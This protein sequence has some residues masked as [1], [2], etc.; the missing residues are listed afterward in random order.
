MDRLRVVGGRL[1]GKFI[2]VLS[3]VR[4]HHYPVYRGPKP[5]R[6]SE[7]PLSVTSYEVEHLTVRTMRGKDWEIKFLAPANWSDE[8]ALDYAINKQGGREREA[9]VRLIDNVETGTY[10]SIGQTIDYAKEILK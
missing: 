10:E 3:R 7:G 5:V 6:L 2:D 4:D 1:N 9:L 8:Q